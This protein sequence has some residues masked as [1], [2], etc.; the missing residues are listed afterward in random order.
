MIEL[1]G[2]RKDSPHKGEGNGVDY[3]FGFT[4]AKYNRQGLGAMQLVSMPILQV[5][6]QLSDQVQEKCK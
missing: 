3:L 6:K 2:N 1:E 4:K 5:L